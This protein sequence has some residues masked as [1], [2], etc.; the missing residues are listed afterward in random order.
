MGELNMRL[1][2]LQHTSERLLRN[3]A[4][5]LIAG[6][7]A[8]CSADTMRFTDGISTGSTSSQRV[9]QQPAGDLYASAAPVAPA[10]S[11]S[12]QRNSLPPVSSA[13]MAAP[14]AAARSVGSGAG[15]SGIKSHPESGRAGAGHGR[16]PCKQHGQCR[17][18]QSC[19]R[20]HRY[21]QYR[22]R[23]AGKGSW[24]ASGTRRAT[25]NG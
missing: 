10:S 16:K 17:R 13:P 6:F 8:G 20:S 25:A 4:I 9:A 15:S 11:G 1:Q 21:A 2:I 12:V 5:V 23:R 7:G 22:K 14:V 19:Q 24:S 18:N 3:V